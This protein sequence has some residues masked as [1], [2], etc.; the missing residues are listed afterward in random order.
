MDIEDSVVI[1]L[2]NIVYTVGHSNRTLEEFI[3]LIARYSIE[4]IIDVRRFPKSMK[5][6]HFSMENLKRSLSERNIGY[7]WLEDLGGYRSK[8]LG[9]DKYQCFRAEGYRNYAAWMQ[10]EKWKRAFRILIEHALRENVAIMC[11]ERF[12]WR[13]HRKLISDALLAEGFVVIHILDFDRTYKHRLTKC[14]RI[15][16]GRLVYI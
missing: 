16:E 6:P 2:R 8:I 11:A 9:A 10:T 13:C 12:P 14:A 4:T 7:L 1:K 3:E 15:V 5:Y